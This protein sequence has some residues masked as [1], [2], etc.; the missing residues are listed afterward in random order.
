[1]AESLSPEEIQR[2]F[3]AYNQELL[4]TGK[5]T[6]QTR[7]AFNDAQTGIRNYTS[8]LNKSLKSLGNASLGIGQALLKGE[9]GASTFNRGLEATADAIGAFLSRFGFWGKMLGT[10]LTVGSKYV[11]EVN[12]QSDQLFQTYQK[13]SK[14]GAANASGLSGVADTMHK[15]GMTLNDA[16]IE[17]FTSLISNNSDALSRLGGT[18]NQGVKTFSDVADS[19]QRLMYQAMTRVT[20]DA[21]SQILKVLKITTQG[22]ETMADLLNPVRLFPNSYQSLTVVT[23]NGLRAVYVNAAGSVNTNLEQELPPYVINTLT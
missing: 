9:Q 20:G 19:I 6:K 13:L 17:K 23:A 1:M 15:F 7:D 18:V 16:D 2:A 14:V 21:V 4:L 10:F 5:V 3:D 11:S 12:K 22:I 8:E